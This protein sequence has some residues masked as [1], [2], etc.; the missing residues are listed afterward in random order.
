MTSEQEKGRIGLVVAFVVLVVTAPVWW[1][2]QWVWKA[3][4][5]EP[6]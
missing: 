4:K 1:P 2:I 6:E 5:G 3:I